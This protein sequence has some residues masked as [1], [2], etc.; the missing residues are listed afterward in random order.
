MD[1]EYYK[2]EFQQWLWDNVPFQYEPNHEYEYL[3]RIVAVVKEVLEEKGYG[4]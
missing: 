2:E 4:G 1:D 3:S